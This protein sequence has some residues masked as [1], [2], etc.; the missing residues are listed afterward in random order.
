MVACIG[1][2]W[3]GVPVCIYILVSGKYFSL[4]VVVFV[5]SSAHVGLGFEQQQH[6]CRI[7]VWC[8]VKAT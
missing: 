5:C 1:A 3:V 6:Q 2:S 4:S 7:G 8:L